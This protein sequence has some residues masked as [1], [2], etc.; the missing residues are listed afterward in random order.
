[1]DEGVPHIDRMIVSMLEKLKLNHFPCG[2]YL[3]TAPL[4]LPLRYSQLQQEK[5]F[6][7]YLFD[8]LFRLQISGQ[9]FYIEEGSDLN[10]WTR[11][12]VPLWCGACR[13]VKNPKIRQCWHKQVDNWW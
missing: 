6:A 2:P 10:K 5:L 11:W 4:F 1:M 3:V 7:G 12:I 13:D 8:G 9:I